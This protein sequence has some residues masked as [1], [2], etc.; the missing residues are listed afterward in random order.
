MEQQPPI[1]FVLTRRTFLK[2]AAAVGGA[3]ALPLTSLGRQMLEEAGLVTASGT[4]PKPLAGGPYFLVHD[5]VDSATGNTHDLYQIAAALCDRI[6]PTTTNLLTGAV[7]PGAGPAGAVNYVDVFLSAFQTGPNSPTGAGV[8]TTT[9]IWLEGRFSGR[10]PFGNPAP[11]SN[12]SSGPQAAD[13]FEQ[14]TASDGTATGIRF[15]DLTP[16]QMVSWYLRIYGTVPSP[17]PPWWPT[18]SGAGWA[19]DAKWESQVAPGGLIPGAQPLRAMYAQGL[20]AFDDWSNQNFGTGFA[21]GSSQEQDVLVAL[22]SNPVLGAASSGGLPGLPA[23]LANPVPPPA[24][25][26]L[27]PVAV[28]HAIQGTYGLPEYRGQGDASVYGTAL[29]PAAGTVWAAIGWDGDTQPLGSSVYQYAASGALN[30]GYPQATYTDT[31]GRA[32]PQGGYV[33]VRPVS[34]PDP[35]ALGVASSTQI[36]QLFQSLV[37]AGILKITGGGAR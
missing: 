4:T 14:A 2:T 25:A 19:P 12:P 32:Q 23:P 37:A 6:L 29:E 34:T 21:S 7:S 30:A 27:F 24:A 35:G 13:D 28:L 11:R 16:A 22:A 36:A 15:L 26:Q 17:L 5:Y 31:A 8:S 1:R 10:S 18:T 33:E 9:P 20:S 3:A